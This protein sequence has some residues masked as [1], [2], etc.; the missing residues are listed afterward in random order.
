MIKITSDN[1]KIFRN[2]KP[3]ADGSIKT[4]FTYSIANK[5]QDGSYEYM[6]KICRFMK[7]KEPKDNCKIKINNAF[8]SFYETNGTKNDYLM[9]MDYD[10]L[11]GGTTPVS[12]DEITLEDDDLPF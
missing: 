4:Y 2:E 1:L 9:I 8:Q 5:K 11:D 6:S 7:D 10:L 3:N 12:S